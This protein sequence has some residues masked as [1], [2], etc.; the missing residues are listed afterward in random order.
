MSDE[1]KSPNMED[2]AKMAG[3]SKM[4]VSRVLRGYPGCNPETVNKV[5]QAVEALGYRNNPMDASL[6]ADIRKKTRGGKKIS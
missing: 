5:K 1:L 2:V 4:T 3:V 6:M